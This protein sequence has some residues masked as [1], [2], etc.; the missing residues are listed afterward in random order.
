[1]KWLTIDRDCIY[2]GCPQPPQAP[3]AP[4]L[5]NL[6]SVISQ[7]P[8]RIPQFPYPLQRPGVAIDLY[9][10]Q[11]AIFRAMGPN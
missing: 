9:D 5:P 8:F 1:M 6:F 3:Q 11:Q 7:V 4:Q 10:I 2:A